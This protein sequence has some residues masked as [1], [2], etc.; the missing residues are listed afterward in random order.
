MSAVRSTSRSSTDDTDSGQSALRRLV[1]LLEIPRS[2]ML[3][4]VLAAIAT[5]ASSFALAALAAWLV[6]TAWTMPNVLDLTVA[7]V[8]VRALGISRGVFRWLDRVLTHDVALR[9]VVSLRT[10]LYSALARRRGDALSRVRRGD[11]LARLGDDAQE[12]GD[13]VIRAIVPGLV[14]VV[15]TVVVVLTI[16][17]LSLPAAACMLLALVLAGVFAP[18]AAHREARFTEAAVVET[19]SELTASGLGVL[20]DATALRVQ[21]RLNERM[22]EL[23]RAQTAHD[24]AIDRA[25]LPSAL[26][27]AS[28]PAV[29]ILAVLGSVLAAGGAWR[30]G[31]AGA[32]AIGM[33]VLLPLSSF[34]AVT[35]LPAAASQLARTRAAAARLEDAVGPGAPAPERPA[36]DGGRGHGITSDAGARPG[37]GGTVGSGAGAGSAGRPTALHLS[38][39]A[40][41]A[42][43]GQDAVRVHDLDLDVA[44]GERIAVTGGS[45]TGKTTLVQTLAGLLEPV[46]G[47]VR[48][49][50]A[51]LGD[52]S[53]DAVRAQAIALLEDA[54]VFATTVHENLRVA[55]GD[56]SAPECAD[57][58]RA[59]GLEDWVDSLPRGLDTMLG[60]DGT[61][62]SGGERRRLLLARAVVRAAPITLLDEPT[63]H[64]DAARGDDLLRRLL[65]PADGSLLPVGASALVVTHRVEAIPAG[66]TVLH[67]LPGGGHELKR[68]EPRTDEHGNTP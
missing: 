12:L 44:P 43:Y 11:L 41:A 65:D 1:G 42:G 36:D 2:R 56:V 39:H 24:A 10:N 55:R 18:L 7:V 64:L 4:A 21:G 53:E 46:A 47:T 19:R 6:T 62:V 40:L 9:G 60:P 52:L 26:A 14:A 59:V 15:M 35:A 17:P 20:D 38:A 45:G 27:A 48:L 34:E 5:L 32:G 49:G 51:A 31:G 63:E 28:V 3:A 61:T 33:L 22:E 68:A 66:T 37:T 23:A 54:H 8:G 57:A 58:L 16:A 67:I 25:A 30:D 50:G 13:L 29:M